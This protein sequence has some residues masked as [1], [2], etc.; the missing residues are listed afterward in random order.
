MMPAEKDH[1]MNK[2][3]KYATK[4]SDTMVVTAKNKSEAIEKIRAHRP[5]VKAA[6]V[7]V[8]N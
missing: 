7:Y 5:E 6:D 3:K 1:T 8:F 4:G 2:S